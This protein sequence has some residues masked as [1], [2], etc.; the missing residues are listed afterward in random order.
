MDSANLPACPK[1]QRLPL[2]QLREAPWNPNSMGPPLLAKL[3]R[4]VQRFGLTGVLVVRP[5][6]DGTYQVLSGNQ[7]LQ[8]LREL[9]WDSAPCVIVEVNDAEAKLLAQTLN[10]LHGS[11]DLGLRA[12]LVIDILAEISPEEVLALLPETSQG[13]GS[14]TSLKPD[15][16]AE[17][18]HQWQM[19]QDARLV[20]F[21]A[22]LTAT[23]LETVRLALNRFIPKAKDGTAENPNIKGNALYLMAVNFL[24][25]EDS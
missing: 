9:Q 1:I 5:L 8:V 18:L 6:E 3:Q 24:D 11:D 13:L 15:A 4:S 10:R 21:T 16:L 14:L 12:E 2:E 25:R 7:R 19:A 23:Q 22:R 20:G 17:H